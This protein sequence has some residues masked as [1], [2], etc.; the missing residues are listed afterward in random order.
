MTNFLC[1]DAV[2]YKARNVI[3]FVI[4]L[5]THYFQQKH[6]KVVLFGLKEMPFLFAYFHVKVTNTEMKMVPCHMAIVSE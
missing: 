2:D 3:V 4:F 6:K 1:C 5:S